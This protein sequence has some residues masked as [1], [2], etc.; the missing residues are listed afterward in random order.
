MMDGQNKHTGHRP[1]PTPMEPL[2][3]KKARREMRIN[4]CQIP[5]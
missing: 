5:E 1:L 4:I 3:G 2:V